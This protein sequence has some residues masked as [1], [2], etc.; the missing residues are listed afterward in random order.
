MP[1]HITNILTIESSDEVRVK[2]IFESI[3]YE[4]KLGTFDFEKVIPIPENIYRGNL[5]AKEYAQYGANNWY[6]FCIKS[7]ST[8]WNSYAYEYFD[9]YEAGSNTIKFFTA[10]SAPHKVY[11]KLSCMFPDVE[12]KYMWADEDFGYNCGYCRLKNGSSIELYT[13][14]GGSDEAN[15]FALEVLGYDPYEEV[16][17]DIQ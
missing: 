15:K 3:C 8:K 6:D 16:M 10:W 17:N 12:I 2:E 13:P 7:W 5:G 11:E 1:N 14:E 9:E 4:G